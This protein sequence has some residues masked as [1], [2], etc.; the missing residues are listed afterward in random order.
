MVRY[1][2]RRRLMSTE[3]HQGD[4]LDHFI[5]DMNTENFIT[6]DFVVQ[7]MFGFLFII[8]DSISTSIALALKLL[9]EHP[10]VLEELTA[11]HE[12]ILK[13]RENSDSPITWEEYKSMTFTLQVINETLRLANISP[14]MFR[15]A[16]KDIKIKGYTIPEGWVI[17]LATSVLHLNSDKFENPLEF[18]PRRWKDLE[19][20][21]LAK[22]FMPF[23]SG[24]KQCAGS[25]YSRVFIA[26]FLHVLVTKYRWTKINGC[27][28]MRSPIIRF[29]NGLH[30]KVSEK[31]N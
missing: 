26:T 25:E 11:E 10:L 16:L 27:E 1:E 30:F 12:A 7:H 4:L 14:G 29:P 28:V 17:L 24:M 23:G 19:S 31:K 6:E 3:K 22:N 18:N 20:S 5:R 2:L 8:F 13:N 21:V 9:A 15:K